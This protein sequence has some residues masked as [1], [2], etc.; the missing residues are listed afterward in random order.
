MIGDNSIDQ[1][2]EHGSRVKPG[3]LGKSDSLFKRSVEPQMGLNKFSKFP[4]FSNIHFR[5][6]IEL[7]KK[8]PNN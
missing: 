2:S 7:S 1:L 4:K 6:L 3:K 8:K 5:I